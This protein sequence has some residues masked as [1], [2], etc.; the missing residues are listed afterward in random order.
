MI[1]RAMGA[2]KPGSQGKRAIS[3]NTIAQGMFWRQN[4]NEINGKTCLCSP[5]CRYPGKANFFNNFVRKPAD[6]PGP[7]PV[8]HCAVA[9]KTHGWGPLSAP[10]QLPSQ[11]AEIRQLV[12]GIDARRPRR[13]RATGHSIRCHVTPTSRGTVNLGYK[14][15]TQKEAAAL[16]VAAIS[17]WSRWLACASAAAITVGPSSV[18]CVVSYF[19]EIVLSRPART[20]GKLHNMVHRVDC[21]VQPGSGSAA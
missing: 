4:I 11:L 20:L 21:T 12:D 13:L 2:R 10:D 17:G 6:A 5:L 14:P 8:S 1:S 3:R 19:R 15:C 16:A 9:G 7:R 18:T